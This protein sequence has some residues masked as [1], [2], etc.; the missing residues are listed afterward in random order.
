MV[1]GA[2]HHCPTGAPFD[3]WYIISGNNATFEN[4]LFACALR[5]EGGIDTDL[6]LGT[7]PMREDSDSGNGLT[8]QMTNYI[9]HLEI[10]FQTDGKFTLV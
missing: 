8:S 1:C 7:D 6:W 10:Q 2:N 9:L 4:L 5:G 3:N